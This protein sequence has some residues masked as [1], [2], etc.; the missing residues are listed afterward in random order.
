MRGQRFAWGAAMGAAL[1]FGCSSS[2]D[3]G[4]L[5]NGQFRYLCGSLLGD[6]ACTGAGSL[7]SEVDLPSVIAVGAT[8]QIGYAP[9]NGSGGTV[10]G[11]NGY[12]IVPASDELALASGNTIVA[13]EGGYVALL[14]R[15]AGNA[16]VDDFVH[17]RLSAIQT[18]Q[19]S[20][21]SLTLV[22][23]ESQAV[24]LAA[25]DARG[26][27]LAGQLACVWQMTSGAGTVAL[28]GTPS[29]G[30]VSVQGVSGGTA[31]LRATC[32]AASVDVP[33]T[34]SGSGALDGGTDG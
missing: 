21:S 17:L 13:Q 24:V 10:E 23:G 19:A 5:G 14:A 4:V 2:N 18:L 11:A 30:R 7:S 12:E 25:H 28:P 16:D 31:T 33:V 20:P 26:A 3:S 22:A 34:V 1:V 29:T 15:H 27:P 32:G 8:F 9:N 6:A